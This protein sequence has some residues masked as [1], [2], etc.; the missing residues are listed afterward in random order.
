MES[1]PSCSTASCSRRSSPATRHAAQAATNRG[2]IARCRA[3]E[4]HLDLRAPLP[5]VFFLSLLLMPLNSAFA[6]AQPYIIQLIIDLFLAHR[7]VPPPAWLTALFGAS[8]PSLPKMAAIYLCLV[9]GEFGSAY[10]QF[11][12]TMMVAQY[13]LSD[14]R[15]ALFNH[16]QR[17]PM[18]FF[19]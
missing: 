8:G 12:L 10:G 5:G 18:S 14:L 15:L 2:P 4:V 3:R 19:D 13:S 7:R 9:C 1:M 11:Y 6:L 16:V 17:L